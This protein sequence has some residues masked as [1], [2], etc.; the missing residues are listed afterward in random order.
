MIFWLILAFAVTEPKI[1]VTP[2]PETAFDKVPPVRFK[3][4]AFVTS[5]NKPEADVDK[6]AGV[7]TLITPSIVE[8]SAIV[9]VPF[10]IVIAPVVPVIEVLR[11]LSPLKFKLPAFEIPVSAFTPKVTFSRFAVEPVFAVMIEPVSDF[12]PMNVI[13]EMFKVVLSPI[14]KP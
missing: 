12:S 3:L 8:L 1:F 5:D 2:E 14:V 11:L 4:P 9:V 7:A 13:F 6:V 10:A